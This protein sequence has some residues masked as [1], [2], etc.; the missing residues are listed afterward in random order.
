MGHRSGAGG[1][2]EVVPKGKGK[3][4]PNFKYR[5]RSSLPKEMWVPAA[6]PAPGADGGDVV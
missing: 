4:V 3:M 1:S 2:G 6:D 5:P